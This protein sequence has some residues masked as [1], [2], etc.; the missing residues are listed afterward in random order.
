L[1]SLD[2]A[3]PALLPAIA[4]RLGMLKNSTDRTTVASV[5]A[6]ARPKAVVTGGFAGASPERGPTP[7]APKR[8]RGGRR[9]RAPGP[10]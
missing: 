1:T 10:R 8:L 4:S 5:L 6:G 2:D 7:P 3:E 9:R